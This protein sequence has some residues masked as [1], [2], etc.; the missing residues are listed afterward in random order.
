V[1]WSTQGAQGSVLHN[2]DTPAKIL[3]LMAEVDDEKLDER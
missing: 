3:E 1:S 2:D